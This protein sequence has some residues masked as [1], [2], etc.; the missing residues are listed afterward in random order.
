[1]DGHKKNILVTGGTSYI[2]AW[3]VKY[4]L[5]EGYNLRITVNDK[6]QIE[7]YKYLLELAENSEGSLQVYESNLLKDGS[8]NEAMKD[9]EIVIHTDYPA[10]N[11][12]TDAEKDVVEPVMN[13]LK[14]IFNAINHSTSVKKVVITGRMDSVYCDRIEFTERGEKAFDESCWN[15]VSTISYQPLSYAKTLWEREAWNQYEAQQEKKYELVVINA[16]ILVGPSITNTPEFPSAVIVRNMING[17]LGAG[18]PDISDAICDVRDAAK[19]HILAA[20]NEEAKGRFIV[21]A[22]IATFLDMAK[23]IKGK[24]PKRYKL[25]K[26][27]IPKWIVSLSA[28]KVGVSKEYVKRNVGCPIKVDNS[29]SINVLGLQYRSIEESIIDQ[30]EQLQK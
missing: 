8:F 15:T 6:E 11:S 29:K 4:L 3:V 30:V 27:N 13:G 1:M 18:T 9:V 26:K 19:A 7:N 5:E 14:N 28:P 2:G 16:G 25:P 24:Y 22:G 12:F 10:F 23:I 17:V 20:F 21:S